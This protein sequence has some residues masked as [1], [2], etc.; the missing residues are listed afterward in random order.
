MSKRMPGVTKKQKN[1]NLRTKAWGPP[2]W[3]YITCA[4][5]G[6]PEKQATKTQKKTYK[7][8]L[9][10]V[11]KTLPC[12]LCRDSYAKFVKKIPI[13]DRVLSSRKNLV[14]WFF[15]I[16]NEVNKKLK[17]KQL[18]Q[19]QMESKY[20]WYNNFRAISCSPNLGGCL[21]ASDNIKIPKRTKVIMFVDE[22][23]IRLRKQKSTKKTK[24]K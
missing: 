20:K 19:K 15:K 24:K 1:P 2:A 3:F 17:C 16:H 8:F 5:M 6:Y 22:Q 18:T 23:A 21:K 11:G 13:T 12:N 10:Y 7:N 14:M 4:L 9:M